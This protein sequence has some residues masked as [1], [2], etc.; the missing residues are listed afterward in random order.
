MVHGHVAGH[1]PCSGPDGAGYRQGPR[2]RVL[3]VDD[4]RA[5]IL[6]D[7]EAARETH[8]VRGGLHDDACRLACPARWSYVELNAVVVESEG[9][10]WGAEAVYRVDVPAFAVRLVRE[11]GVIDHKVAADL[12]HTLLL[13]L[14]RPP[15]EHVEHVSLVEVSRY[16]GIARSLDDDVSVQDAGGHRAVRDKPRLPPEIRGERQ[17]GRGRGEKLHVG[18]GNEPLAGVV[19]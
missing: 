7:R 17:Q 12:P 13:Q 6:S 11:R 2:R 18:C 16:G 3:E 15:A 19:S 9:I 1:H 5:G 8:V 4:I 10:P 14:C